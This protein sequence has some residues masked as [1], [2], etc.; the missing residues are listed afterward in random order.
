MSDW[1]LIKMLALSSTGFEEDF[2]FIREQ[3]D[4]E[5]IRNTPKRLVH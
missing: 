5:K 4:E 1:E 2:E 3:M